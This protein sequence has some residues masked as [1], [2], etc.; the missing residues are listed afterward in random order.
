MYIEVSDTFAS[1][2]KERA[3]Y[4]LEQSKNETSPQRLKEIICYAA[5]F[6]QG[7][8]EGIEFRSSLGNKRNTEQG[9]RSV[10]RWVDDYIAEH[11]S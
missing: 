5:G 7:V 11:K 4:L 1:T 6:L 9:P 3:D 8:S 10:E 2:L